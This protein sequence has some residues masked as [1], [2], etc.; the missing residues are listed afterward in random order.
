MACLGRH[1]R[2]RGSVDAARDAADDAASCRDRRPLHDVRDD[3]PASGSR[4]VRLQ[5]APR[6]HE[7]HS[8]QHELAHGRGRR[9]RRRGAVRSGDRS[10]APHRTRRSA[11][12]TDAGGSVMRAPRWVAIGAALV[13][14]LVPFTLAH[15]NGVPMSVNLSYMDLSNFGSKDATGKADLLFAEGIVKVTASGLPALTNQRYQAWLVNSE[16]GDAISA[17]RFNADASGKVTFQGTLPPISSF[18]FDLF[19]ITVEPEPD[20]A[21][22][23]SNNRSIGGRFSLVG[24][25][26]VDGVREGSTTA[27]GA[28]GGAGAPS[29]LPNTGDADWHMDLIRA[30]AL[31]GIMGLSIFIGMRLSRRR[32]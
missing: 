5:P 10:P 14:A 12:G 19:I 18:G 16:Q 22:Q 7:R 26:G 13:L 3:R 8:E 11:H 17:G 15:A 25:R 29:Q 2:D 23:P 24:Q 27:P 20:D 30:G 4:F 9:P 28:A 21:P 1:G 31:A 6:A 32:A